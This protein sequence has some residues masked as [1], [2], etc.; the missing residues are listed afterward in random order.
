MIFGDLILFKQELEQNW[1]KKKVKEMF[2]N[3][4]HI[5]RIGYNNHS[6]HCSNAISNHP[7]YQ[8]IGHGHHNHHHHSHHYQQQQQQQQSHYHQ[9][10]HSN[11]SGQHY[12]NHYQSQSRAGSRNRQP[13]LDE[14][15]TFISSYVKYSLFFFNLIFW[16]IGSTL[17]ALGVWSFFEEYEYNH[18]FK[19]RNIFDLILHI[20]VA[21]VFS[22]SIVFIMSLMGCLGALR[23]NLCLIKLVWNYF[24][25]NWN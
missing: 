14:D 24:E 7:N 9:R 6:S 15:F 16:I 22:G 17:I 12:R 5:S 2:A 21:L 10:P 20:S 4:R 23:E 18:L 3:G 19:L 13:L 11:T 1:P 25:L 8:G